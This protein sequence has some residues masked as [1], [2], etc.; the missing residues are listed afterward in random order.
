MVYGDTS[1]LVFEAIFFCMALGGA[2]H[3]VVNGL[4]RRDIAGR[5]RRLYGSDAVAM[6]IFLLLLCCLV[7]LVMAFFIV[8]ALR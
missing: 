2:I 1:R 5:Y 4:V 8:R 7:M 6:G 3:A